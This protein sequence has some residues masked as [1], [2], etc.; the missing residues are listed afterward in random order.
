[1]GFFCKYYKFSRPALLI[2]FILS[3]KIEKLSIQMLALYDVDSLIARPIFLILVLC[4]LGIFTYSF[5]KKGKI[6]YA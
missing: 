2:G 1:L 6:D 4:I 3:D 5:I